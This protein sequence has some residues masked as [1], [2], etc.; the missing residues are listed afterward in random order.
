MVATLKHECPECHYEMDRA[1][2]IG[3][4]TPSPQPGNGSIC[5]NCGNFAVFGDD[6]SLRAPTADELRGAMEAKSWVFVIAMQK[7]IHERGRLPSQCSISTDKSLK[8][9]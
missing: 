3:H 9:N 2:G 8:S 4:D 1:A 5:L 6:L 7:A